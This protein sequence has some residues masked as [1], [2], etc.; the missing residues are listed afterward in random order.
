MLKACRF[1]DFTV[2]A[3]LWN[4]EKIRVKHCRKSTTVGE[5]R[6]V[7]WNRYQNKFG[8]VEP[9]GFDQ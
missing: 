6:Q 9:I 4:G 8:T 1:Q 3:L 5:L 7:I 2:C